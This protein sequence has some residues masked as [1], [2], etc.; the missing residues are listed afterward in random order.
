MTE[1]VA[2]IKDL[3]EVG[4]W[5]GL[6]QWRCKLCQWDTLDGEAVMVE[7]IVSTHFP[8]PENSSGS[9][10]LRADRFGNV[11]EEL[12]EKGR[13]QVEVVDVSGM[14]ISQ[15]LELVET[16]EISAAEALIS[17][18]AGKNRSKLVKQLEK[19]EKKE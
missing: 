10:I 18:K 11:V 16:G 13:A 12:V 19:I 2:Q 14:K 1:K 6:Q 15:V 9:K 7:H 5:K 4:K 8:P 17:E 3:F